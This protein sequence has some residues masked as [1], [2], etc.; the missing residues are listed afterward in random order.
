[1]VKIPPLIKQPLKN[2]LQELINSYQ[3]DHV[4]L[5]GSQVQGTS[6]SG[7]D[8]DLAIFSTDATDENRIKIMADCLLKTMPYHLDIQ[9]LV[10][11]LADYDSDNDFIQQEIIGRGIDITPQRKPHS[12]QKS[13]H[14]G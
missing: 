14:Q 3:L 8:I 7:S 2:Y 4:I 11:P 12:Q 10:Y 13:F 6:H 5:F 9:P 1:M